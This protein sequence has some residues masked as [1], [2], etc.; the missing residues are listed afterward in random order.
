MCWVVSI[1]IIIAGFSVMGGRILWSIVISVVLLRSL[2]RVSVASGVIPLLSWVSRVLLSR[3][4]ICSG[5]AGV[6]RVTMTWPRSS[7]VII[8]PPVHESVCG[9]I[10]SGWISLPRSA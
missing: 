8:W 9:R 1:R 5:V 10:I 3:L 2:C 6:T 4:R 7:A